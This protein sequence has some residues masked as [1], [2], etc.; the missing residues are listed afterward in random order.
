MADSE[1]I[2]ALIPTLRA[3]AWTLTRKE[4]D[5]DDLVH[6]TLV[7]AISNIDKFTPGTNLRAW[8]ATIMRNTFLNAIKKQSRM[9]TGHED[10]VS[11]TLSVP[12]TQEWA[13]RGNEVMRIVSDL[14]LHYRETLILVVMLGESYDSAAKICGVQVGTIKS[15][16]NRARVMVME[17]LDAEPRNA[18]GS[19]TRV[20]DPLPSAA[21][22]RL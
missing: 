10:C 7:K 4:Q 9:R 17:A 2:V 1:D 13:L 3:Y 16:V 11:S 6:D 22:P 21:Q 5:V 18:E 12:A 8:L 14:P 19:S 20:R 15:R